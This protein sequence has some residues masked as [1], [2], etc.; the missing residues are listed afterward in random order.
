MTAALFFCT[1]VWFQ[2]QRF[3]AKGGDL[4]PGMVASFIPTHA[5]TSLLPINCHWI[6][7]NNSICLDPHHPPWLS[8]RFLSLNK[9]AA[10]ETRWISGVEP[11]LAPLCSRSGHTHL[12][13]PKQ[14]FRKCIVA[15]AVNFW[16]LTLQNVLNDCSSLNCSLMNF[17]IS[18]QNT[19]LLQS[20]HTVSKP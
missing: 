7:W 11:L 20:Q 2:E 6:K 4:S 12:L 17:I 15:T 13:F 19:C 8:C 18:W 1:V 9:Q 3:G 16:P 14:D 5:R 10:A